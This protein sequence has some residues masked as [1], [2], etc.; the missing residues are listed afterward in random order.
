MELPHWLMVGGAFL[1][2]VGSIGFARQRN[3]QV[4]VDPDSREGDQTAETPM[5]SNPPS[6][7]VAS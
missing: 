5:P 3:V 1:L 7:A 2:V 4:S 6:S